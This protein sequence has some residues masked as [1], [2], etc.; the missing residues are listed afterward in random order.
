MIKWMLVC[1]TPTNS[2]RLTSYLVT[3]PSTNRAQRYLILMIKGVLQGLSNS[4][5]LTFG[6]QLGMSSV[7][8]TVFL[9]AH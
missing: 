7:Q 2:A 4:A 6:H 3:H 5:C 9:N 8:E 1:P